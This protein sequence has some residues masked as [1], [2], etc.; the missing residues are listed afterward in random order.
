L[1]Q[2]IAKAVTTILLDL[3]DTILQDDA[4]T[5]IAFE[6]T[7]RRAQEVA[8]VDPERL[9]G[10]VQR[11]SASIWEAGPFPEWL[12]GIG[13]SE[14]EGLRARFEGEDSHWAE[15]REWGPGFR[16]ESWSRALA[17]CGVEDEDLAR[18]LDARFERERGEA[19]PFVPGADEALTALAERYRLGIVTNGIPDVQRTKLNKTGLS[20]RFETI[21]V[22][23][24]LGVGKPDPRIYDAALQGIG[25]TAEETIM[26]GDNFRRDVA[27]PQELGIRGVWI[28]IGRP[29]PNPS[30]T[31]FLTIETL[32]KLPGL[33]T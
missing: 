9:I 22:S 31:P 29:S 5:E 16:F 27:G 28:S 11:I 3:D 12:D 14:I 18:D 2:D 32:A 17:A 10:E 1:T 4:A 24:E 30:V 13:T 6:A 33:L 20:S 26:V 15:M 8:G 19:N 7:A 21:I 23:G 25:A